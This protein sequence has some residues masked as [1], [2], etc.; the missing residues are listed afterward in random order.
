MT[1]AVY[2]VTLTVQDESGFANDRHTDRIVVKVDESP[3]AEAG[4]DQE[5]CAGAE[6]NFDGSGSRDFDGV[7]NRFSWDFGDGVDRRRRPA[8]P[9]L[10]PARQ[11]PRA[12][13]DRGRPGRPVRQHRHRRAERQRGRGAGRAD[14]RPERGRGRRARRPSMPASRPAR[15]A[16]S[17]AGSGTS[18]TAPPPRGRRSSTSTRSPA[19]TSSGSRSRPTRPRANATSRAVQHYVVANAPPVA[20][21]GA[22]RLVGVDQEVLFDGSGAARSRRRHHV[23]G[24]WD[25]G[26]GAQRVRHAR[27]PSLPRRAANSRSRS[28]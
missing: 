9:R 17:R 13:D 18:A 24:S 15:P 8:G 20:D 11:L 19:P 4:A 6:V 22:D 25:F 5:V 16:G 1:G 23:A 26:D 28:P 3:I 7:V 14:R 10:Q 21:A 2:P 12:A 27:P